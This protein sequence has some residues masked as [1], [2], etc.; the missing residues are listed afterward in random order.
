MK[1][2]CLD[3]GTSQHFQEITSRGRERLWELMGLD[4]CAIRSVTRDVNQQ[5]I[6][7]AQ[8]IQQRL[9]SLESAQLV[10]RQQEQSLKYLKQVSALEAQGMI[11]TGLIDEIV[12][13]SQCQCG[14]AMFAESVGHN[15]LPPQIT[16]NAQGSVIWE[17]PA[18][19]CVGHPIVDAQGN[20]NVS[21][22][23]LESTCTFTFTPSSTGS[24]CIRPVV[25]L[26]GHYLAWT[27]GSCELEAPSRACADVELTVTVEQPAA[28]LVRTRTVNV[29]DEC[30]SFPVGDNALQSGFAYD[31]SVQG[32]T[33]I[34]AV[35]IS[36]EDVTVRVTNTSRARVDNLGRAWVDMQTS[37]LFYFRVPYV[38]WGT[39]IC[40]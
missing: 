9:E 32:G 19:S 2:Q 29:V 1:K 34:N 5:L 18:N 4:G 16:G 24:Y 17:P 21:A 39:R 28:G 12:A 27:W 22:A 25:Q 20:G 31:S 37:P 6:E 7:L 23:E 11:P 10:S 15:N 35:L 14:I 30:V 8:N 36:G 3:D 40:S 13:P 38:R 26:N 33:G